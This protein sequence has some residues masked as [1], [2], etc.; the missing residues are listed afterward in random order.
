MGINARSEHGGLAWN[1][2]KKLTYDEEVQQKI[3]QYSKGISPLKKVTDSEKTE[4]SSE[5]VSTEENSNENT[6]STEE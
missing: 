1:F 4:E 3:F 5:N 2:L 6:D